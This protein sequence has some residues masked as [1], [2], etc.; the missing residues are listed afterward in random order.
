MVVG[1]AALSAV[2]ELSAQTIKPEFSL[3]PAFDSPRGHAPIQLNAHLAWSSID[4]LE[5]RLELE[6]YVNQQPVH[7]WVSRD[8]VLSASELTLPVMAPPAL[9]PSDADHLSVRARFMT[10]QTT[11]DLEIHDVPYP[12]DFKRALTIG[13]VHPETAGLPPSDFK[14]PFQDRFAWVEPFRLDAAQPNADWAR[15]L[16]CRTMALEPELF[17]DEPLELVAFDLLLVTGAGLSDLDDR[18]L[19]ALARWVEAGGAL[20]VAG[21]QARMTAHQSFLSRVCGS[22]PVDPLLAFDDDGHVR[23]VPD[24]DSQWLLAAP[25]VGRAIVTFE[26]VDV[27]TSA[28]RRD[29][30]ELWRVRPRQ[31]E[32]ILSTGNWEFPVEQDFLL[33]DPGFQPMRPGT[34]SDMISLQSHLLPDRVEG[35]PLPTVAMLLAACLLVVGPGDYLLLGW[36][37]RRRW[38]WVLFPAVAI[39]FSI[40]MVQLA[41]SHMGQTDHRTTLSVVD[42]TQDGRPARI[43]RFELLFAASEKQIEEELSQTLV[44]PLDSR[45]ESFSSGYGQIRTPSTPAGSPGVMIGRV[46]R[47]YTHVRSLRQW[48]PRLARY[49]T[50]GP[51]D[52]TVVPEFDWWR[53][54]SGALRD[55]EQ[56]NALLNDLQAGLPAA[57]IVL[58]HQ[59]R[60]WRPDSPPVDAD[61]GEAAGRGP[62]AAGLP[63][64][65]AVGISARAPDGMFHIVSQIAPDAAG[66]F[67]DLTLFDRDDPRQWLLLIITA[68]DEGHQYIYRRL[69]RDGSA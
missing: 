33:L 34:R 23:F 20:C 52:D 45:P 30:L 51:R 21:A 35:V 64:G 17:P 7:T 12:P 59:Q 5:G 13:I 67:E 11:Y 9:L 16:T 54:E 43:S 68:D 6:F 42:L 66:N 36:F 27:E 53:L 47:G 38:T 40:F 57:R 65:F 26:P 61:N 55:A 10:E 24:A 48:T 4:L 31:I 19:D 28:W 15:H 63:E 56:R 41:T 3:S 25:G 18:Q 29:L 46:P 49:T 22:T 37:N 2:A 1:L 60:S 69:I 39:G 58:L 44:V 8:V 14:T 32:N 50:M 62:N